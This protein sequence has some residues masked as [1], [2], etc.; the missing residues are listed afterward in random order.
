MKPSI[1]CEVYLV[2]CTF[3]S[4]CGSQSVVHQY[5]HWMAPVLVIV[6]CNPGR[7]RVKRYDQLWIFNVAVTNSLHPWPSFCYLSALFSLSSLSLFSLLLSLRFSSPA[8]FLHSLFFLSSHSLISLFSISLLFL[9][10]CS[11]TNLFML[12]S[13]KQSLTLRNVRSCSDSLWCP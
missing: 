13:S 5:I 7:T 3:I 11:V 9:S 8:L 1:L 2:S 12:Y 10:L 4:W 6:Y